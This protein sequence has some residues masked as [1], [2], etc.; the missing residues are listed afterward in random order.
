MGGAESQPATAATAAQDAHFVTKDSSIVPEQ[1]MAD[2]HPEEEEQQDDDWEPTP[3]VSKRKAAP[4][5]R[6]KVQPVQ[7]ARERQKHRF[8]VESD[9][10]GS[11]DEDREEE[12][13]ASSSQSER[14]LEVRRN[15]RRKRQVSNQ[16]VC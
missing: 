13:L 12:E 15:R 5:G 11:E 2:S 8:V 1:A 7:K 4:R 10:Q 3:V 6:R 14:K 9:S 16:P